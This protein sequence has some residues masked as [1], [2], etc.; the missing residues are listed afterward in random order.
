MSCVSSKQRALSRLRISFAVLAALSA[1]ATPSLAAAA[2][3]AELEAKVQSL[4]EQLAALQAELVQMK[5]QQGANSS[6]AP[7]SAPAVT[8]ATA[9]LSSGSASPL[10]FFGY[11]ELN[12]SQPRDN[13]ADTTADLA[14]FVLGVGYRFDDRTRLV[15]E[16]EL[17]HAVSSS[18]D[19]GEVEIEQAYIE[20]Q[21]TN[22]IFAKA[23]LF[24]IPTG[25]LNENHE[26]TRYY[27]VFRNFVE[28][29]IIP[30]TWR[31]GGLAIQGNSEIGLRWDA[32]VSTGFDLSKWDATATEGQESPLGS[33]HQE[34]ALAHGKD[35][36]VFGAL[37]YTGVPGLRVGASVFTGG[38]SQGQQGFV[39]A[40][41]TLWE[42]HTRWTPGAFDLSGLYAHG[43]IS[44][45]QVINTAL[46]GNPTLI[47]E[48]F[49][50]WYLQGAYRLFDHGR[51]N[52][53]PFVRYERF[54]TASDYAA[55]PAGLT[56]D[57]LADQKVWTTGFNLGFAP[58]V[59]LKADYQW[60]RDS[61]LSDRFD[62]GIGYQF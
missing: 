5:A 16:V 27:G 40:H 31:E 56:P 61:A 24:L 43:H 25:L 18:E 13:T 46:V 50:G 41:I 14:R 9:V 15:S 51:Y 11:G 38:A 39:G 53:S 33:I 35:L 59:V 57:T 36:S 30:T 10:S 12:Y 21:L 17:E 19:P 58:G 47:P 26:P 7:A 42:A 55:L 62:L 8:S 20:H 48:N 4:A 32:G 3:Q 60:F 52:F 29:A 22:S 44:N 23:G 49:F 1:T 34:L 54:N 37:N 6:S 28:T 2:T 45:T